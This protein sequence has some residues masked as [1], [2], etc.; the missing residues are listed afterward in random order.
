MPAFVI[1]KFKASV[2]VQEVMA[3]DPDFTRNTLSSRSKGYVQTSD[4]LAT[5]QH[6]PKEG[7][8]SSLSDPPS[9]TIWAKAVEQLPDDVM[10]L[11][12]NS[13]LDTLPPQNANLHLCKK[14]ESSQCLLCSEKQSLIH[15]L[16][17]C[18]V[19][20]DEHRYNTRHDEV[21]LLIAAQIEKQL[22]PPTKMS[23]DVGSNYCFPQHIVSTDLRQDIVWW[24]DVACRIVIVEL[25]VPFET[26]FEAAH[27][28][29]E[30]HQLLKEL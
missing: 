29:K 27:E 10:K 18:R 12:L 6:L 8:M 11:S 1:W 16:N 13:A 7:H 19:A 26:S 30:L 28:C 21:L 17:A 24:N 15:V 4:R 5:L 3:M 25:T 23:V 14:K 20:R 9:A 2:A 22:T